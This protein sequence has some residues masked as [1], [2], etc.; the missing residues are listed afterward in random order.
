LAFILF[1]VL[2][3]KPNPLIGTWNLDATQSRYESGDAPQ[4]ASYKI[5]EKR[6][7][8]TVSN[9]YV[10][11]NGKPTHDSYELILDGK[12]HPA[13]KGT[14]TDTISATLTKNTLEIVFKKSGQIVAHK[15]LVVSADQKVMTVTDAGVK[16]SNQEFKNIAVYGKKK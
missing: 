10:L 13:P 15:T 11:P 16:P 2:A 6:D 5:E 1:F 7:G 8:L 3:P 12:D 14:L 4:E 9:D